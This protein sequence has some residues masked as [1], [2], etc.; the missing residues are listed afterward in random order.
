MIDAGH[1]IGTADIESS[2]DSCEDIAEAAVVGF[3]HEIKGE[4][5]CCFIELKEGSSSHKVNVD[6]AKK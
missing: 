6:D 3:P 2:I 5:I 4:G 1:R